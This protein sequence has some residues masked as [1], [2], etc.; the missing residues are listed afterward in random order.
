MSDYAG[1]K[2]LE[3][4]GWANAAQAKGYVELFARTSAQAKLIPARSGAVRTRI[5]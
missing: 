4:D 5:R 1:F 3:I 2:Q